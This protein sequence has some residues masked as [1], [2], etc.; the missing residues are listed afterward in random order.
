[1]RHRVYGKQLGRNTAQRKA[2]RLALAIALLKNERIH[3]TRAKADFVRTYVEKLITTAKRGLAHP[4]AARGVHARRLAGSR[5]NND[6]ELV[7]KL[8]DTLAVRYKDREGGYTRVF[9]VAARHGDAAE[10]VLLEL[11][12]RETPA[13]S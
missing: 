7:G 10:M 2:L 11:V 8:F 6:R 4:D 13:A 1:M 12:D 3:T 9:K 5:L